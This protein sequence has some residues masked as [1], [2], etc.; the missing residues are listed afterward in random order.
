MADVVII[1]TGLC[2]LRS[3]SRAVEECDAPARIAT[4]AAEVG[5][6]SHVILPGVGAFPDA[7]DNLDRAGLVD[8][9]NEQVGVLGVP[10]LGI[11]LGM[12]L[13]ATRGTEGRDTQGL[14]WI[15]GTVVKL[16][17]STDERIPHVGWNEI[18]LTAPSR[19]FD[20]ID[21]ARDFYF[22]HG[23]ALEPTVAS[24][25]IATTP[26]AGGFVSAVNRDNVFGVQFHPEKSQRAGFQV[27]RNFLAH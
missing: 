13:L 27:L 12:Q 2:N 17:A 16:V 23:W 6:P 14:G 11:C 19:L 26:Y 1:D 10:F 24:D 18:E 4:S 3:I 7:M 9:L 15:D 25:V 8:E 5:A 22:V 21:P 20:G